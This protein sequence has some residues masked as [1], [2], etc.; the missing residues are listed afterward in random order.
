MNEMKSKV[1]NVK[2]ITAKPFGFGPKLAK[3]IALTLFRQSEEKYPEETR[4][5]FFNWQ[6][7]L[8]KNGCQVCYETAPDGV[9]LRQQ[10]D[11]SFVLYTGALVSLSRNEKDMAEALVAI[12][13]Y[14]P[15]IQTSLPQGLYRFQI[16]LADKDLMK[17]LSAVADE[18]IL[19][20][21]RKG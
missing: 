1:P 12:R 5:G 14:W 3:K 18:M 16:G 20:A 6:A 7:L 13:L 10:D 9:W 8:A 21:N 2:D 11:G 15:Q 17:E 19:L 4:L